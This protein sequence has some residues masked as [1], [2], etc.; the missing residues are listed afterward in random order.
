MLSRS[1]I[2]AGNVI[3]F[4]SVP[5]ANQLRASRESPLKWTQNPEIL[6]HLGFNPFQWVLSISPQLIRGRAWNE[7][8]VY[9]F[10]LLML[11]PSVAECLFFGMVIY[12]TQPQT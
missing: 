3:R 8:L 10:D 2:Q 4:A 7:A 5:P 6:A 11:C 9:I 12:H 1:K